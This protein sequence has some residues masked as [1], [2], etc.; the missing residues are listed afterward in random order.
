MYCLYVTLLLVSLHL[1]AQEP[2]C[3][4]KKFGNMVEFKV[5]DRTIGRYLFDPSQIRPHF[6]PLYSPKG[7]PI[8]RLYPMQKNVP[9][10]TTDHIHHKGCW[11]GHQIVLLHQ[12]G[13][14]K[15]VN[16]NFWADV[17]N[18]VQQQL[19]KQLCTKTDEPRSGSGKASLVTYNTWQTVSGT[20]I[21]EENR[22]LHLISLGEASLIVFDIDLHATEGD[23]TFGD[24]KDG[25]MAVRV[26]DV[27][28]EK[29]KKGGLL[30]NAEGKKHMGTGNNKDRQG[31]WGLRSAW[32]DY[33]GIVEEEEVGITLM[34]HPGNPVPACWHARDYGLL[35][36]NPFGRTH[37][38]FP[39]A[40]GD[41]VQLKKGEHLRFRYGVLIHPGNAESGK[42]ADRYQQFVQVP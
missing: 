28:A 38:K 10:E 25:F 30:Q 26:A 7:K 35:T 4:I 31:C 17:V 23:L 1:Q 34:D 32:V 27:L 29:S 14:S 8:T 13:D 41:V 9:G 22:T 12:D 18:P 37:A 3:T 16:A 15:P 5:G 24:E 6:H 40:Q 11:V 2:P 20:K 19:G 36:A 33:S 21:L 39:D 42:V